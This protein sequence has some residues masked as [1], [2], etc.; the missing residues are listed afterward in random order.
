MSDVSKQRP[1][2]FDEFMA[3]PVGGGFGLRIEGRVRIPVAPDVV[4]FFSEPND[5]ITVYDRS[6]EEDTCWTLG[7]YRDGTWFRREV[8]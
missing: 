3:L 4:A 1:R 2:S 8:L 6:E 7:R 5:L